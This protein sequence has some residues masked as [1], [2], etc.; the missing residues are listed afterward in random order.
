[1]SAGGLRPKRIC[2]YIKNNFKRKFINMKN[3]IESNCYKNLLAQAEKLQRHNRQGSYKTRE[4]YF[5]EIAMRG[6]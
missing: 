1:V 4:R 6:K 3:Y 5:E 2:G